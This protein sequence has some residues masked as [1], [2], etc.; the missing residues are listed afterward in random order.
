M[1]HGTCSVDGCAKPART[2]G[3][4]SAHYERWRRNGDPGPA[5]DGRKRPP[6]PPCIVGGCPNLSRYRVG[7][8]DRHYE[9]WKRTGDPIPRQRPN[10]GAGVRYAPNG[11]VY[12][13]APGH[14][15]AHADG[16]VA[17]HRL[18]AWDAGILTDPTMQVHHRDHDKT[19]N[20]PANLEAMTAADHHR[21][22]ARVDGVVNQ[23][24]RW[25]VRQ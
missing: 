12:V 13:W 20:D 25:P 10:Y 17:E 3:W 18:V 14:P 5:G 6:R 11:Y 24:G 9:C 4:C 7:Y 22:H 1:A 16:Y 8:C 23:Y 2:R 21:H 19:N 15:L